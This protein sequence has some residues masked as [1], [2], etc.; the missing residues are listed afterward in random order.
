MA[1]ETDVH[2]R[3]AAPAPEATQI[4]T[5]T[6]AEKATAEARAAPHQTDQVAR[7]V[8]LLIEGANTTAAANHGS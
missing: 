6:T 1:I 8:V 7:Q 5:K 3:A 4:A 2:H